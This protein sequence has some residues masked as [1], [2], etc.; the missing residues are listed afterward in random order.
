MDM[1]GKRDAK[2]KRALRLLVTDGPAYE[3]RDQTLDV[4][5][6]LVEKGFATREPVMTYTDQKAWPSYKTTITAAG[7]AALA[8]GGR[9]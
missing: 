8:E 5:S 9:G 7:R 6:A 1:V 2:E 3:L 4:L